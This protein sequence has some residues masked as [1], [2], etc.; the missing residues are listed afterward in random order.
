MGQKPKNSNRANVFR[1][2]PDSRRS[3]WH[4]EGVPFHLADARMCHGDAIGR[5]DPAATGFRSPSAPMTNFSI[6]AHGRMRW[7]SPVSVK[8]YPARRR[9]PG[10]VESARH[11]SRTSV[12]PGGET[13]QAL[14]A[15]TKSL[16]ASN[17]SRL[18]LCPASPA[19]KAAAPSPSV[20]AREDHDRV[21]V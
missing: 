16:S 15:V 6:M 20:L 17:R 3:S 14:R 1:Y 19:R 10:K 4:I 7:P 9:S 18:V 13:I 8:S 21:A 11:S 12:S 5:V 2:S